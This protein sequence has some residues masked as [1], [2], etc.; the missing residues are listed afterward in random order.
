MKSKYSKRRQALEAMYEA[1]KLYPVDEAIA[2][3]QQCSTAGFVEVPPCTCS[4]LLTT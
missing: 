4:V 1:K 3:V 2:L